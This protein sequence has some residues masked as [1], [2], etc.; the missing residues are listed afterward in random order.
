MVPELM[1]VDLT[2]ERGQLAGQM[3]AAM[4]ADVIAVEPPGGSSSRRIGPFAGDRADPDRS[5][6]HWSYNR[7]KRSIVLD[8]DDDRDRA[9]LRR[10]VARADVVIE[11]AGPGVMAARGLGPDDLAELNPSLVTAAISAFG[12]DGPK[13]DW[14]ATDLTLAAAAGVADLTGDEDRPPL[15]CSLPQAFHHAAADAVGA[16]MIAL[17]E[18]RRHSGL[19]QHIDLSAQQSFSVASQSFLLS[20]PASGAAASRVAGGVRLGGIDA[21]VQLLWPCKDGQV[22]VT[23]LFGAAL[24]PFT[25]NLMNWVHEEGFCDEATRDKDWVNYANH[26][27]DGTEPIAEYERVKQVLTDF[28]ATKEKNELLA[29]SFERRVLIAPVTS[30]HDVVNSAHWAARETWQDVDVPGHGPVRFPGAFAKLTAT[31]LLDLPAA[32]AID[33]HR[34]E[35]LAELDR[36]SPVGTQARTM[37]RSQNGDRPRLPLEGLKVADFMW[38]FAGPFASRVLADYGAEVVRVESTQSLDALRTTGNFLHDV[39]DPEYALQFINVNVG[40]KDITLDLTSPEGRDV[41]MDLVRWGDVTLESFSPKAMA[42]WGLDY[43]SLRAVRPDLIMASS[44]LMG[45]V[46]PERL[47]AG[48]G[49][50]AAAIS[51]FFHITGWPDRA[52]CGPF[53]AYTDYV[54]PRFLLP[55]VLGAVAHRD[56]TGEGQYIDLSQAEASMHLLSPAILDYTVNGRVMERRGNDDDVFAPHGC[57]PV[58]GTD[59]WLALAVTDDECWH[60]CTDLMGRPDLASLDAGERRARRREL[61]QL[62]CAWTASQDGDALCERLQAA[63]IAAHP[64]NDTTSAATDPQL[65]HRRHFVEVPH[66]SAGTSWVE[67]S[68]FA[69]RRTPARVDRPSPTLGEHSWEVLTDVLGYS[70]DQA[71]MLAAAEVL[72]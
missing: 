64:V 35:I 31:P 25:Q 52:P 34:D 15:R 13:A 2:D 5:L 65:A 12:A 42:G 53:M 54:S 7:G 6:F 23:F 50:M 33:Q 16:I 1:V 29:A 58:Q 62:M 55:A 61:D 48:F 63:G 24:G 11:S 32:P 10:L 22:S 26:L 27:I 43:E 59:R 9:V 51:G 44:C 56:R 66:A 47:L 68:R 3:L 45:Q 71:A 28:L 41:A 37:A 14:A 49:T 4:G 21:K 60:R 19:G 69:L 36:S 40:K 46:G 20:H 8:L 70:D 17:H 72:E 57:Y 18:R 39:T 38:V 30:T 67:G